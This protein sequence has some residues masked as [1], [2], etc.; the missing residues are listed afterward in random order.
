M[1]FKKIYI[2]IYANLKHNVRISL[3][4]WDFNNKQGGIYVSNDVETIDCDN[5]HQ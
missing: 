3:I 2:S 1:L 4:E 5:D